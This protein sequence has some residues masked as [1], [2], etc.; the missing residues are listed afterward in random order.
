MPLQPDLF[1]ELLPASGPKLSASLDVALSHLRHWADA[2]GQRWENLHSNHA[3]L[4]REILQQTKNGAGAGCAPN[5]TKSQI[6]VPAAFKLDA[7][8]WKSFKV[9]LKREVNEPLF[10]ACAAENLP[11]LVPV[12]RSNR[13]GGRPEN[14]EA[15]YFLAFAPKDAKVEAPED[16]PSHAKPKASHPTP[17]SDTEALISPSFQEDVASIDTKHGE[18]HPALPSVPLA[19]PPRAIVAASLPPPLSPKARLV[20]RIASVDWLLV[21]ATTLGL[22]VSFSLSVIAYNHGHS[23]PSDSAVTAAAIVELVETVQGLLA[24]SPFFENL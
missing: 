16:P 23:G 19:P 14:S 10:K 8:G 13:S 24:P 21:G 1:D 2:E 5:L 20:Q 11:V 12:R 18:V 6:A 7:R 9:W 3:R 22:M 4:W 17:P 15:L